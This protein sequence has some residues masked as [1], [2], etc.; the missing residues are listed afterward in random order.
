MHTYSFYI[1]ILWHKHGGLILCYS[2]MWMTPLSLGTHHWERYTISRRDT[3]NWEEHPTQHSAAGLLAGLSSAQRMICKWQRVARSLIGRCIWIHLLELVHKKT[4]A[5]PSLSR[6]GTQSLT[7]GHQHR[8][9]PDCRMQIVHRD[10]DIGILQ[11]VESGQLV[12]NLVTALSERR[13]LCR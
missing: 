2:A 7:F 8:R 6:T 12:V 9:A 4:K 1:G 13:W 11:T 5:P 10:L 3:Q